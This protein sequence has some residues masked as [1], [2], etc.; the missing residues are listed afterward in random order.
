MPRRMLDAGSARSPDAL[1][2]AG[3]ACGLEESAPS[4]FLIPSRSPA[5]GASQAHLCP[6]VKSWP[7]HPVAGLGTAK[8]RSTAAG[9][10]TGR[11]GWRARTGAWPPGLPDAICIFHSSSGWLCRGS[12]R[13]GRYWLHEASRPSRTV[14]AHC[15]RRCADARLRRPGGLGSHAASLA[16]VSV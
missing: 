2:A 9:R 12:G 6:S 10:G 1:M 4:G 3:S 15:R 8:P 5:R 11:A 16:F 14:S 7:C 13:A